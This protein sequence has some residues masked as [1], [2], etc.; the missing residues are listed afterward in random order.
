MDNMD[1]NYFEV[2]HTQDLT[3]L[4]SETREQIIRFWE[5]KGCEVEDNDGVISVHNIRIYFTDMDREA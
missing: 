4:P 5:S 2:N 3:H 1:N